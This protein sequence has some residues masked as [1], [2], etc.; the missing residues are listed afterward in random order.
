V[1]V[2]PPPRR[3]APAPDEEAPALAHT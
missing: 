1:L 2:V 3:L